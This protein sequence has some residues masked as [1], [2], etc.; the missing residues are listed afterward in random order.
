MES[1]EESKMTLNFVTVSISPAITEIWK[2]GFAH[3]PVPL[4]LFQARLLREDSI[5]RC[6]ETSLQVAT[7][8]NADPQ[9]RWATTPTFRLSYRLLL[10]LCQKTTTDDV[11]IISQCRD[12]LSRLPRHP[13]VKLLEEACQALSDTLQSWVGTAGQAAGHL[14][15]GTIKSIATMR[16]DGLVLQGIRGG[17]KA[18]H[19]AWKERKGKE[20]LEELILLEVPSTCVS[21]N[22]IGLLL[23]K[24]S[25]RGRHR[26]DSWQ[27]QAQDFLRL[28]SRHWHM[29]YAF[30]QTSWRHQQCN[31]LQAFGTFQDFGIQGVSLTQEIVKTCKPGMGFLKSS[32]VKHV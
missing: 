11:A 13:E 23:N 30:R 8:F 19:L 20:V 16:V 3:C 14:L 21:H 2:L 18:G 6:L 1:K 28:Q 12:S 7:L 32:E 29:A 22:E 15:L 5:L 9:A 4:Q 17:L 10:R 26:R 31:S 27:L 25:M 24:L